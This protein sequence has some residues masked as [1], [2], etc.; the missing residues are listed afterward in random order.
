MKIILYRGVLYRLT[1]SN[2]RALARHLASGGAVDVDNAPVYRRYGAS[3][4]GRLLINLDGSFFRE[5]AFK[6][7]PVYERATATENRHTREKASHEA[8]VR[9]EI[10]RLADLNARGLSECYTCKSQFITSATHICPGALLEA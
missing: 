5:E 10:I 9:A 6:S 8:N 4:V 7:L 2:A 3:V 1:D